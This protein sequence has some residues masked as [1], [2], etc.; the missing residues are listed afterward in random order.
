MRQ[1]FKLQAIALGYLFLHTQSPGVFRK[2]WGLKTKEQEEQQLLA[3]F[4]WQF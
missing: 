1:W 2:P 4:L 3:N